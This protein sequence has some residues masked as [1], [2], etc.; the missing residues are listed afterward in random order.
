MV[1]E[2]TAAHANCAYV[3]VGQ[4]AI[5]IANK[6]VAKADRQHRGKQ[7]NKY[8]DAVGIAH[9]FLSANGLLFGRLNSLG[10]KIAKCELASNYNAVRYR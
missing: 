2:V 10:F 8:A 5:G 4:R 1:V 9:R 7:V 6:Q 3:K